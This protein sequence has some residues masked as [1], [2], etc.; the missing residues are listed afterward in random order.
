MIFLF[1]TLLRIL[2]GIMRIVTE[3][4]TLVGGGPIGQ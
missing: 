3:K 1:V 2:G 4:T